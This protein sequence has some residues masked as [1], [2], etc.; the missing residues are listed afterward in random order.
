[1]IG[2]GVG[3]GAENGTLAEIWIMV[4]ELY[5]LPLILPKDVHR[6]K[7]IVIAPFQNHAV[8]IF[9]FYEIHNADYLNLLTIY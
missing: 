6:Q 7:L 5:G 8:E 1:M 4:K 3:R 2:E 9:A